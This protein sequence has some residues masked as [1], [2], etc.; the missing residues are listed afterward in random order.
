MINV[1]INYCLQVIPQLKR[2]SLSQKDVNLIENAQ[3]EASLF[4]GVEVLC[5]ESFLQES[6]AFPYH[7][8]ER[9]SNLDELIVK[10]SSFEE[11]LSF[12]VQSVDYARECAPFKKLCLAYLDQLKT[13]WSDD[14]SQLH[15]LQNLESLQVEC[16][17]NLIK[18]TPSFASF[19]NLKL[20]GLPSLKS[21]CSENQTL[22][23]PE[24]LV[25][26]INEC[27]QMKMFCPGALETPKLSDVEIEE[28][29]IY[30]GVSNGESINMLLEKV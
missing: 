10:Y 25:V 13:I 8:L 12:Q 26:I 16:C 23:F 6:I 11:I 18:L 15:A 17:S 24:L 30:L 29:E 7:F 28:E 5:L 27:D 4:D 22:K 14:D 9:F 21:F 20:V 3:F 19:E 2:L 1:S